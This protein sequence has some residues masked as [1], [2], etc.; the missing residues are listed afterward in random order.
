MKRVE[1]L[2]L[3]EHLTKAGI[4]R[5]S[6]IAP[7]A[8]AVDHLRAD[9]QGAMA[10]PVKGVAPLQSYRLNPQSRLYR[11]QNLVEPYRRLDYKSLRRVA[12]KAWLINTI[13]GHQINKLRP[14][15]S[16]SANDYDRGFKIALVD[17]QRRPSTEEKKTIQ[18]L[19]R[20]LL[21][22]GE[23]DPGREDTLVGF[24][25]KFI[26]DLYTLDQVATEIQ[27]RLDGTPYAFWAIDP[28][29]IVRAAEGGY[30]GDQE[31]K[32]VQEIN[33]IVQAVYTADRMVFDYQNARSD[34]DAFG[35]GYSKVEQAIELILTFINT[36]AYNAGAF[37]EDRL[38]RG[39]L[40]LQGDADTGEVEMIEDYIISLMQGG[41]NSKW[42]IPIVPSGANGNERKIEWVS[43]QNSNKDMEYAQWTEAVWTAT[44]A[45]FDTDL[46]EL[47][48]R[49]QKSTSVLGD[50]VAGKIEISKSRGLM[51]N[52]SFF[53]SHMDKIIAR[54]DDRFCLKWTGLEPED[55]KAKNEAR[56]SELRTFK[57]ID[58]IRAEA[59]DKPYN[60]EWSKIP[61]NPQVIQ[62]YMAAKQQEQ[63]MQQQ[64]GGDPSGGPGVSNGGG[65]G[66]PGAYPDDYRKMMMGS[67]DD[68]GQDWQDD[69]SEGED[70][71]DR[72]Q[73]T[74]QSEQR[75]SSLWDSFKKSRSD[76]VEIVV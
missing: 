33:G 11:A 32:W 5:K 42:K 13:I 34:I 28:A 70:S 19:E 17:G 8:Q 4:L 56:E 18:N 67:G 36:F 30:Q 74:G 71:Q 60:E 26:R 46:E 54:L 15:L 29:T 62:L 10:T 1:Q 50:N 23:P 12:E 21:R 55:V 51:A 25:T 69:E 53:K 45:L 35:Y 47:G 39:M 14:F 65:D 44:A 37:T 59:D 57:S 43:F 61:L 16:V 20:W 64:G 41:P 6:K 3:F 24:A 48:I 63:A 68:D 40:L 22:T 2:E 76:V 73:D 31:I 7:A 49:T 72:D 38:P 75:S 9:A 66:G 52:M 27:P 58:Q